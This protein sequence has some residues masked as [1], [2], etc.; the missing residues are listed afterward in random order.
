[1]SLIR[2]P[3]IF[4]LAVFLA[5]TPASRAQQPAPRIGYVYPAGGQQGTTFQVVVGGQRLK[6]LKEVFVSGSGVQAVM[7]ERARPLTPQE[8]REYLELKAKVDALEAKR[9]AAP[10]AGKPAKPRGEKEKSP[11]AANAPGETVWTPE[12]GKVLSETKQKLAVLVRK[13][14]GAIRKAPTPALADILVAQ[15]ALAADAEPGPR[16]I[17]VAGP[18]GMSNPLAF[19]VGQVAEFSEVASETVTVTKSVIEKSRER[20]QTSNPKTEMTVTLP[21]TINGQVLPGEVNRYRFAAKKGQRLVIAVSARQLIPYI[22]DAVPGWFQATLS[23]RNAASKELAYADSFR[24]DPDPVLHFEVPADG[25]Y[26]IAIKDSLYRGREDFVYRITVGELPFVTGIFPLGGPAG[27][28]TAVEAMGWNLSDSKLVVDG[29]DKAP[30]VHQVSVRKDGH[31]SNFVPFSADTLPECLE[32]ESNN[33]PETAQRITLPAIING[34]VES[35]EDADVFCFEGRTGEHVVAEVMARRL[36]SPLDSALKLTDATG[37][38]IAFNDDHADKGAG[39]T[40]HQ[41]DS[42]LQATL[43]ANGVYYLHLN[44]AQHKGGPEHAY[45]L[46]VS[47]PRP[48]FDL[49]VA[50]ASVSARPGKAAPLTVYALRKDGFDG[51]IAL[52]LKDAPAG[53]TLSANSIPA[54]QAV[55]RL[56]LTVQPMIGALPADLKLEGRATIQGREVSHVALPAEDMMQ[57]FEYRHLVPASEL[58][59]AVTGGYKIVGPPKILSELPVRIPVG[60]TARVR[61]AAPTIAFSNKTRFELA[62]APDGITIKNVIPSRD[63]G[64][65]VLQCDAKVEPGRKGSLTVIAVAGKPA[66][67]GRPK[68]PQSQHPLATLPAIPFEI[69]ER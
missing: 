32:K 62:N 68:A 28:Q 60:G 24:F 23:L 26:A 63:G 57:A 18:S 51:D 48:D 25:K 39:L 53:F 12:D 10:Q 22:S 36:N 49:R 43:P 45:R 17:R 21:A 6:D 59:L 44:D 20:P 14:A 66:P 11:A 67:P 33:T 47:A 35:P 46:R 8:F 41:A 34:R 54:T 3:M 64:E 31:V 52:S 1:M 30:G 42:Y 69:I 50:P 16:E 7:L 58:K 55:A 9:L 27:A 5:T 65:I 56:T 38:Q 40:T 19:H 13:P 61:V 37:S 15:V 4:A 2:W 29:K